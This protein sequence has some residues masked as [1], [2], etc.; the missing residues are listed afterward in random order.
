MA[1][2][3]SVLCEICKYIN[4]ESNIYDILHAKT[5]AKMKE[6]G[7]EELSVS[8]FSIYVSNAIEQYRS[9]FNSYTQ[10]TYINSADFNEK[11]ASIFNHALDCHTFWNNKI[12]E[13]KAEYETNIEKL[14]TGK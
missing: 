9:M 11:I 4:A 1:H 10:D 8:G 2:A 14:I 7:F 12:I 13:L 6:N 3:E 5:K